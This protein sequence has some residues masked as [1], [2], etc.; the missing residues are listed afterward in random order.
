[1]PKQWRT[2]CTCHFETLAVLLSGNRL[3][4]PPSARPC[5]RGADCTAR[6]GPDARPE[7]LGF[8]LTD[9]SGHSSCFP[10]SSKQVFWAASALLA[11]PRPSQAQ[12][13]SPTRTGQRKRTSVSWGAWGRSARQQHC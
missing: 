13:K 5:T 10:R 9:L 7:T 11:E 1:M 4:Q 6:S 8:L 12:E 2:N 3:P